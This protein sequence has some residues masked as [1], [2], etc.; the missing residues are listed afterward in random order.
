[1][2]INSELGIVNNALRNALDRT[3]HLYDATTPSY[4]H[5]K[6]EKA[7]DIDWSILDAAFTPDSKTVIFSSWSNGCMYFVL[8]TLERSRDVAL[9][10]FLFFSTVHAWRIDDDSDQAGSAQDKLVMEV[11]ENRFACFSVSVSYDGN[12]A[13]AG[14]SDG[15]VFVY[16]RCSDKRT[17]RVSGINLLFELYI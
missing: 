12:Y 10:S 5:V 7:R 16:D 9:I 1:M 13:L 17:L 2:V 11:D 3:L 15:W 6:R 4:K 8:K 14:A